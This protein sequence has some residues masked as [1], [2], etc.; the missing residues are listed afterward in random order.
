MTE[1]WIHAIVSPTHNHH[2][3]MFNRAG[4]IIDTG[5]DVWGAPLGS[6]TL[7]VWGKLLPKLFIHLGAALRDVTYRAIKRCYR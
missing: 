2:L 6:V 1:T 3:F 4:M 5:G 7:L